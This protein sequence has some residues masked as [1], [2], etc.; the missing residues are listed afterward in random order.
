MIDRLL[1][2]P[3]MGWGGA[4]GWV[5]GGRSFRGHLDLV[6]LNFSIQNTL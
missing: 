6:A 3:S 5:G 1:G 4:P 2:A